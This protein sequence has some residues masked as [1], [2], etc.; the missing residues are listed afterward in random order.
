MKEIT[1]SLIEIFIS[2]IVETIILGG[3]FT[4]ISNK[5]NQTMQKKVTDEMNNI[6]TQNKFIYTEL[7]GEI[8]NVKTDLLSQIKESKGGSDQ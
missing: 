7:K 4:W 8:Q 2:L 3:L 6:E 5:A 1:F